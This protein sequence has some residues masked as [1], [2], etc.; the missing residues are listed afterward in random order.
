MNELTDAILSTET[1]LPE[2]TGWAVLIVSLLLTVVWLLYL[3]R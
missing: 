1:A 2:V 3:Y